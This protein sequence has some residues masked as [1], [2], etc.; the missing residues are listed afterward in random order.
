MGQTGILRKTWK[1]GG[2]KVKDSENWEVNQDTWD[3]FA[4]A[5]IWYSSW[6]RESSIFL[7]G[8]SCM[9]RNN[10]SHHFSQ[11]STTVVMYLELTLPV[12]AM[13]WVTR[14]RNPKLRYIRIELMFVNNFLQPVLR[15][16]WMSCSLT[17]LFWSIEILLHSVRLGKKV[18]HVSQ[19]LQINNSRTLWLK[20][21]IGGKSVSHM[22]L[23]W[24]CLGM[25]KFHIPLF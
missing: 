5:S 19:D 3:G 22:F 8:I 14:K 25:F 17:L 16:N 12:F 20:G 2:N 6:L 13:N 1:C 15:I 11:S 9:L 10:R 18:L 4:P 21:P 23:Y 7:L 24:P